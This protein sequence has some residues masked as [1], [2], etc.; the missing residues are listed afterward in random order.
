MDLFSVLHLLL[1]LL[2]YLLGAWIS[3]G[4]EQMGLS[5]Q[6]EEK[7]EEEGEEEDV[8]RQRSVM[9]Y[10]YTNVNTFKI[11]VCKEEVVGVKG[12]EEL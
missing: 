9:L 3:S 2:H 4:S 1:L 5:C 8:R 10:F 6:K 7:D 12:R 11:M